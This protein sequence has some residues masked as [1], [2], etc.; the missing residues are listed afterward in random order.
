VEI[1][2]ALVDKAR[3]TVDQLLVELV[4]AA[5][6]GYNRCVARLDDPYVFPSVPF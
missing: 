3:A 4:V 1:D 6:D 2:R 5:R